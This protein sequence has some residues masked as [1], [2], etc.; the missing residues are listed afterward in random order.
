M[1]EAKAN[2][3]LNNEPVGAVGKSLMQGVGLNLSSHTLSPC[4]LFPGDRKLGRDAI[5]GADI[6]PFFLPPSLSFL[7]PTEPPV[8]AR[9]KEGVEEYHPVFL[10]V[11]SLGYYPS[12]VNSWSTFLS[13]FK[14]IGHFL[15]PS[16][17][18]VV[19]LHSLPPLTPSLLSII[20]PPPPPPPPSSSLPPPSPSSPGWL[21]IGYFLHAPSRALI[22][23][24]VLIVGLS[25]R[26]TDSSGLR[27]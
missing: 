5:L 1:C 4:K 26:L 25:L 14:F 22:R 24:R 19:S 16:L 27:C 15:P 8:S 10:P 23:G 11:F 6:T 18:L 17:S 3:T 9:E 20:T 2:G 21:Q 13:L 12:P 7:F